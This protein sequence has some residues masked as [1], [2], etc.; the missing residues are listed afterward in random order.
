MLE[1]LQKAL[2]VDTVFTSLLANFWE[3]Y[4]QSFHNL[5]IVKLQ[6]KNLR[7]QLFHT[8]QE[9]L[10]GRKK[11]KNETYLTFKTIQEYSENIF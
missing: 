7:K 4:S 3:S 10:W 6:K 9:D 2:I 8:I 1:K 11:N 5:V